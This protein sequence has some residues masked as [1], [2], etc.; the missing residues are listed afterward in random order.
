M[1]GF[2]FLLNATVPYWTYT[3]IRDMYLRKGI[4]SPDYESIEGVF[5][6]A[7]QDHLSRAFEKLKEK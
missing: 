2:D 7:L 1:K 6:T 5:L 4:E 3:W